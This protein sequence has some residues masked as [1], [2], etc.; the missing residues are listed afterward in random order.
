MKLNDQP[1][2]VGLSKE[3]NELVNGFGWCYSDYTEEYLKELGQSIQD[4]YLY[5]NQGVTLCYGD[6]MKQVK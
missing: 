5:T 3:T 1:L 4:V 6:S 2:F